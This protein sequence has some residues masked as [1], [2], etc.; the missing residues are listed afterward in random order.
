[1]REEDVGAANESLNQAY[2]E[3]WIPGT[4]NSNNCSGFLKS[5][6]RKLGFSLPTND[7]ADG[8]IAYLTQSAEWD[9][10]GKGE[11]GL[12]RA[13][14]Y[15]GLGSVVVAGATGHDYG[16][17]KGHVAILLPKSSGGHHAPLIFGGSEGGPA[18]KGT[19]TIRE[20]WRPSKLDVVQFFV[21]RT[22]RLGTYE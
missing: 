16:Q 22:A 2:E 3:Q 19:K 9:A 4:P 10:L 7:T 14:T 1:M 6:A 8:I 13:V 17:N 18:S 21:H 20:V 5:A 12:K 11:A 15:A